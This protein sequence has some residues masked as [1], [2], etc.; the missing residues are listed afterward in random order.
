MHLAKTTTRDIKSSFKN[1]ILPIL[2]HVQANRISLIHF[3]TYKKT[4][5]EKKGTAR[6][7]SKEIAYI[8]SFY[9]WGKKYGYLNGLPFRVER[10]PYKR[11]VP[12]ILTFDETIRFIRAASPDIYRVFF[13]TIYN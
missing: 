12:T 7:I 1:H 10:L 13:L 8:G 2:G 3:H 9:K 4:R 6:T 5:I 11:P